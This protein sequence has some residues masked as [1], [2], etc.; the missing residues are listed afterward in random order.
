MPRLNPKVLHHPAVVDQLEDY[1][2]VNRL[3]V[4]NTN[5]TRPVHQL[6]AEIHDHLVGGPPQRS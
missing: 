6:T 3:L 2:D 5:L 1:R 4:E